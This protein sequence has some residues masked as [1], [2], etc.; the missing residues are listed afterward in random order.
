MLMLF[1]TDA[2]VIKL[3]VDIE[4]AVY[5]GLKSKTAGELWSGVEASGI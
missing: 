1:E 4:S 5:K 3:W 2:D